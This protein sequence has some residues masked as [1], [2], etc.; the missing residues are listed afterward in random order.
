MI[1]LTRREKRLVYL[2]AFALTVWAAW[3]ALLRPVL[4][5]RQ[6]LNRVIPQNETAL[7]N[8]SQKAEEFDLLRQRFQSL[9]NNI[10]RQSADFNLPAFVDNLTRQ[11]GLGDRVRNFKPET[12]PLD[13][14]YAESVVTLELSDLTYRQLILDVLAPL[15]TAPALL[16]VKTLDLTKSPET[17]D[18]FSATLQIAHLSVL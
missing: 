2:T 14:R 9:Q 4:D 6:T 10:S 13:D 3:V 18:R 11:H 7:Q 1:K 8:I 5:R 15:K 12:Q 17:S 16:R